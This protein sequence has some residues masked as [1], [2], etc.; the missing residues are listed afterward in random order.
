MKKFLLLI[1]LL[2]FFKTPEAQNLF[3]A[4]KENMN[5]R[6]FNVCKKLQGDVLFYLVWAETRQSY[7][8]TNYDIN[9]T[10]D[11]MN[12]AIKWIESMAAKNNI[13]LKIRL[14]YYQ[15]DTSKTVYQN[16]SGS[17]KRLTNKEDGI[18]AVNKW[19]DKVVR[20]ATGLKN[21]ERFIAK[22]RDEYSV[23]NVAL[24]FMINNY[25]KSDYSFSLNTTSE[26]DV[27]YSIISSKRPGIMLHEILHLFGAQY[28]YYH[29]SCTDKQMR[30]QLQAKFPNDIMAY[31]EKDIISL[32]IGDVTKYFIGWSDKLDEQY[33]KLLK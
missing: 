26:T 9:S 12:V 31:P 24:I 11:S 1:I 33:E 7:Q 3:Q 30:R 18:I 23:E 8:W 4:K 16:F 13:K 29:P 14:D 27:E 28:L 25:F 22:L 15:S 5:G 21:R 20:T 2:A 32:S 19:T 6:D 10:L 17:I